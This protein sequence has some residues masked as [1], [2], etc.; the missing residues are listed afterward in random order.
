MELLSWYTDVPLESKTHLR[1]AFMEKS[2]STKNLMVKSTFPFLFFLLSFF[3]GHNSS[4]QSISLSHLQLLNTCCIR[5]VHWMYTDCTLIVHSSSHWILIDS[6]DSSSQQ[7]LIRVS[8]SHWSLI[9]SFNDT[10]QII[11]LSSNGNSFRTHWT[12]KHSC[13][14]HLHVFPRLWLWKKCKTCQYPMG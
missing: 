8:S 1:L 2:C 13:N 5:I 11:G 12:D 7:S 4:N 6:S 9:E 3:W 10:D 14:S